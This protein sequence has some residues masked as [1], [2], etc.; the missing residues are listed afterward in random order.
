MQSIFQCQ[1][2]EPGDFFFFILLRRQNEDYTITELLRK[3]MLY[4]ENFHTHDSTQT[5]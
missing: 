5:V 2:R 1:L 4:V 3:N